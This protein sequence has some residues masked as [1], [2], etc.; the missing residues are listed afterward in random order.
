MLARTRTII[1]CVLISA[2]TVNISGC[3]T[4]FKGGRQAG[5]STADETAKQA[6]AVAEFMRACRHLHRTEIGMGPCRNLL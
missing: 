2:C 1:R 3:V 5:G 6:D 4:T